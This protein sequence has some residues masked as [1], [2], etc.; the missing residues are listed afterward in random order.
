MARTTS[1]PDTS[2]ERDVGHQAIHCPEHGRTESASGYVAVVWLIGGRRRRLGHPPIMT[3]SR[4]T[5]HH[6][7]ETSRLGGGLPSR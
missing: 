2:D 1:T 5:I 6:K 3:L 4:S 7:R